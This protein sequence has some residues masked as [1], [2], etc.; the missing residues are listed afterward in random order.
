MSLGQSCV[1]HLVFLIQ[2]NS[3]E[4]IVFLA[5]EKF[6][7]GSVTHGLHSYGH[8][9]FNIILTFEDL[10]ECISTVVA[11]DKGGH[12]TTLLIHKYSRRIFTPIKCINELCRS[13][14]RV[15]FV[16]KLH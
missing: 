16:V 10:L 13:Q 15:L 6:S 12:P 3:H 5:R 8:L 11:T 4:E 2:I 1:R 14:I 9:T 7:R